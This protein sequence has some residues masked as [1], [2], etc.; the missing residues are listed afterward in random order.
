MNNIGLDKTRRYSNVK[1]K[2]RR[3]F[4]DGQTF[5]SGPG[6]AMFLARQLQDSEEALGP[7]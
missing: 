7:C 1:N 4:A 2:N 3:S 5:G 6:L